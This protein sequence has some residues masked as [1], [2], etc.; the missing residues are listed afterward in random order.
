MANIMDR[1]YLSGMVTDSPGA[2]DMLHIDPEIVREH[3]DRMRNCRSTLGL[4]F[5]LV[6]PLQIAWPS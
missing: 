3:F 1:T 6:P 2:D 5:W 4:K